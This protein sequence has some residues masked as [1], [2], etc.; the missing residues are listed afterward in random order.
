MS[1]P[2]PAALEPDA[3]LAQC[4]VR[5]RKASGPGGQRRNKVETG[6]VLVH[7]PT[8]TRA[9][10]TERRDRPS[11]ERAALARLRLNLAL[12]VRREPGT[13]PSPLWRARAGG[14]RI[15]VSPAHP[16]FPALLAEALDVLHAH[17]LDARAAAGRLGVT[18]SQLVKL[19]KQE[20]RALAAWNAARSERGEHRLR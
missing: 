18:A 20:P 1:V 10:A 6:V 3:L 11:N 9:E 7:R 17:D 4:E 8:G 13:R 5:A 12:A 15:R 2:H 19:V 16:D 14:G